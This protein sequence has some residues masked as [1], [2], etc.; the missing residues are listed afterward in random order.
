MSKWSRIV[1]REEMLKWIQE[2]QPQ[3]MLEISGDVWRPYAPQYAS[4]GYPDF[5]ICATVPSGEYDMVVAEQVWE[6]LPWPRRAAQNVLSCLKPGGHFLLSTPFLVKVHP[7]PIDC[8]RWTE[9]G[10]KYFLADCGFE[11]DSV[12]TGA[13]GN[14]DV[15]NA[16]FEQWTE[17]NSEIHSLRNEPEFPYHIWAM[18]RKAA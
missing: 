4:V 12:R 18:A 6:H 3:S 8:T 2:I 15:I 14:R 1:M 7:C 9:T 13:W 10:L 5:D 17:Y 11:F 16:N